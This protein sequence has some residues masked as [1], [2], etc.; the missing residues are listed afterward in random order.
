[1]VQKIKAFVKKEIVFVISFLLAGISCFFV[2]PTKNYFTYFDF[3]V[4]FLLFAFM[5][6]VAG[7]RQCGVFNKCAKFLCRLTSSLRALC[8]SLV[9]M[10]FVF[11]MFITNDVALLTFVPFTILLLTN[12]AQKKYI[13]F[14]VALETIAANLGSMLTPMGNPQN[15]FLYSKMAEAGY[16]LIDFCKIVFPYTIVSAVLIFISTFLIPKKNVFKSEEIKQKF[17]S[18]DDGKDKNQNS[19][20]KVK[21]NIFRTVIYLILFFVCILSVLKI[22]PTWILVIVVATCIMAIQFK[23]LLQVDYMLL[24]TFVCFFVFSGNIQNIELI[25][26]ILQNAVKGREFFCGLLT[27]Q[28]ISNLPAT[29]LLYPFAENTNDLLIGVD[30]GGLGTLVASLAS[31]ISYKLYVNSEGAEGKKFIM[32]FSFL[33]IVFIIVLVSSKILFTNFFGN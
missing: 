6:V 16:N 5:A 28:V 24:L 7:L 17:F 11:S 22:I 12:C 30:I 14:V 1:M 9:F 25:K 10:C 3:N 26:N 15:L 18:E 29:L 19:K 20:T 2:K 8:R 21:L 13:A 4:L 32:N 27:S 33:S 23:I 31:L